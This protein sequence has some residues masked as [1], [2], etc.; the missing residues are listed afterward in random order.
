MRVLLSASRMDADD[1][2]LPDPFV[3][4]FVGDQTFQ[5]KTQ[6]ESREPYIN[7]SF[8]FGNVSSDTQITF[9]IYDDDSLYFHNVLDSYDTTPAAVVRNGWDSQQHFYTFSD[10]E[11]IIANITFA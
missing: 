7:K 6:Y 3:R 8:S 5:T 9:V 10:M 11:G 2:S 1:D 4:I